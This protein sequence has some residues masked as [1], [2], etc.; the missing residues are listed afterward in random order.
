[1]SELLC[2]PPAPVGQQAPPVRAAAF[3]LV[4]VTPRRTRAP[5]VDYG[6]GLRCSCREAANTKG[7]MKYIQ[8]CPPHRQLTSHW[9]SSLGIGGRHRSVQ[10]D[11]FVGS[12]QLDKLTSLAG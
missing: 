1:M 11:T 2:V 3:E 9:T 7:P 12:A 4:A 5:P 8:R 6:D 10:V